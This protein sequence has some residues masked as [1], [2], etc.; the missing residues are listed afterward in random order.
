MEKR[1]G[2][3]RAGDADYGVLG[4]GYAG[5]RRPDPRIAAFI[6]AAPGDAKAVL[7]VGAV[8]GAD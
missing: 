4:P 2:D 6:H 8:A 7:N 1:F 3:G 5:F